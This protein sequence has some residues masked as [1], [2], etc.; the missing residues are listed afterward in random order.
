[1]RRE[2]L[3]RRR[4]LRRD[5]RKRFEHSVD[6]VLGVEMRRADPDRGWSV[7]RT[8]RDLVA[9][10]QRIDDLTRLPAID[11][12]GGRTGQDAGSGANR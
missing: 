1:M 8:H 2:R 5:R 10:P 6:L 7:H 3:H 4:L 9:V 12:D 11:G